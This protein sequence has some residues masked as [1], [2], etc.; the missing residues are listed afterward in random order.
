MPPMEE[1][2]PLSLEL[3]TLK[4]RQRTKVGTVCLVLGVLSLGGSVVAFLQPGAE[5]AGVF[6]LVAGLGLGGTGGY[7][8][9][10]AKTRR[11]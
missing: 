11:W 8:L 1:Q 10:L 4:K 2:A 3:R 7:M 5:V 9:Y 6:A